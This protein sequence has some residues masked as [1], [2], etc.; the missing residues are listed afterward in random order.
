M[1]RLFQK[2]T[3][4]PSEKE[5]DT[6]LAETSPE[7]FGVSQAPADA[8]LERVLIARRLLKSLPRTK[9]GQAYLVQVEE[10]PSYRPVESRPVGKEIT[11]G[12]TVTDGWRVAGEP[13]K[14]SSRHFTIRHQASR[15]Y[16]RDLG[17]MNGTRVNGNAVSE[18]DSS[19]SSGD[20]IYA[21]GCTFLFVVGDAADRA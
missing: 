19:L 15:Y 1:K 9:P 16:L 20:F 6:M 2:S 7:L 5:F 14:L 4:V 3:A 21:G 11:V 13:P 18:T 8:V 12:R 17:S 10:A